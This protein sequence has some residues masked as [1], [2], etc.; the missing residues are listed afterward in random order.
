MKGAAP[1]HLA[2]NQKA[3]PVQFK[4]LARGIKKHPSGADALDLTRCVIYAVEHPDEDWKYP[5]DFKRLIDHLGGPAQVTHAHYDRQAFARRNHV[6]FSAPSLKMT[7]RK[8]EWE[9][10]ATGNQT[11]TASKKSR[12]SDNF[13]D[14]MTN[15]ESTRRSSRSPSPRRSSL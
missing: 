3:E 15:S 7:K 6:K 5:D 14:T 1:E 13:G 11:A 10:Q 2:H 12:P 8:R 9:P 4:D